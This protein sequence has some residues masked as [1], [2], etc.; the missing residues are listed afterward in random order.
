MLRFF[1]PEIDIN[2]TLPTYEQGNKTGHLAMVLCIFAAI[3]GAGIAGWITIRG[4]GLWFDTYNYFNGAESMLAGMGF[5]RYVEG[6]TYEPITHFPPLYSMLL[7]LLQKCG[8]AITSAAR[9]INIASLGITCALTAWIIYQETNRLALAFLSA[10]GLLFSE[11]IL[12]T[13]TWALTEP[14]FIALILLAALTGFSSSA[15]HPPKWSTLLIAGV[16]FG[17]IP[18]TRYLGFSITGAAALTM[19][20]TTRSGSRNE[21]GGTMAFCLLA[22]IPI[23]GWLFRN[24]WLTGN[25]ADSPPLA[26]HPPSAAAW[27]VGAH[28]L[29]SYFLPDFVRERISPG[30]ANALAATALFPVISLSVYSGWKN[31]RQL[32]SDPTASR[33]QLFLLLALLAYLAQLLFSVFF[34]VRITPFDVR[35]LSPAYVFGFLLVILS[36]ESISKKKILIRIGLTMI[37]ILFLAFEGFRAVN[38]LQNYSSDGCGFASQ[39][40]QTSPTMQ[41]IRDLPD[42]PLYTNEVEGVYLLT[43]RTSHSIPVENNPA[44][45]EPLRDYPLLLESMRDTLASS[46]GRLVLFYRTEE[47]LNAISNLEELLAGLSLE[48]LYEDGAVYRMY[49]P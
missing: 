38:L 7:F 42:V 4:V 9:G 1:F 3:V 22:V 36:L 39:N 47:K 21:I 18:Y 45:N 41:F 2:N 10:M 46:G 43:N 16:L 14:I 6:G 27:N 37:L 35:I 24:I 40:W 17:L 5:Q 8:A 49:S 44:Q 34:I 23:A 12:S 31:L 20:L 26:W 29:L 13:H 19:I 15:S 28:T 11:T 30:F 32:K 33:L 25:P 48:Q